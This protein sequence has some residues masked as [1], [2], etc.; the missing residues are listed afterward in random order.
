VGT[1]ISKEQRYI[2]TSGYTRDIKKQT[3]SGAKFLI[4][5]TL[6]YVNLGPK[7]LKKVSKTRWKKN[8]TSFYSYFMIK[9]QVRGLIF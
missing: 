4:Q 9:T 1:D 8:I 3:Y 7:Y 5:I 2:P 6:K